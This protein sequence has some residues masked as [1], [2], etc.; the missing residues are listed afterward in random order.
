MTSTESIRI[1]RSTKGRG[2]ASDVVVVEV[3]GTVADYTQRALA[4][5]AGYGSRHYGYSV[6]TT[7]IDQNRAV[8]RLHND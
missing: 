7:L 3:D 1:I 2:V 4:D 5:A 8:V 6:D